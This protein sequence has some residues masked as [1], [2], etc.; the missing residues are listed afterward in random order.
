MIDK[1]FE[2]IKQETD[3]M[4]YEL[5]A[6]FNARHSQGYSESNMVGAM[7]NIIPGMFGM[8]TR[9]ADVNVREMRCKN[10]IKAIRRKLKAQIALN[11]EYD[12]L[13]DSF[14]TKET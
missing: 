1:D 4:I 12:K 9:D 2:R 8:A 5:N 13:N 6:Y 11:E 3:T 14:K 10:L 7:L